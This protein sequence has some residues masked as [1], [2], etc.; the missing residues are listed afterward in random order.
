[1]QSACRE[2]RERCLDGRRVKGSEGEGV[3][4]EFSPPPLSLSL[5]L[6]TPVPGCRGEEVACWGGRLRF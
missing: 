1:V 6:S 5:S 3:P 2:G 4:Q